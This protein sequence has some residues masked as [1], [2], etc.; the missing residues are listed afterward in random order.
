M[1]ICDPVGY[2]VKAPFSAPSILFQTNYLLG[3]VSQ[4]IYGWQSISRQTIAWGKLPDRLDWLYF[5]VFSWGF[6]IV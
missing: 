6:V 1:G 2:W 4:D 5:L 3:L